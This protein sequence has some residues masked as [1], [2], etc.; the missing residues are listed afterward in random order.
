MQ[1]KELKSAEDQAVPLLYA[2]MTLEKSFPFILP[3]NKVQ[4]KY[5]GT[6]MPE[7]TIFGFARFREP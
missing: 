6:C 2:A 3:F 5:G 7:N 1:E 4:M